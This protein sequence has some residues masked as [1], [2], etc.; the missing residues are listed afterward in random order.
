MDGG[1][2]RPTDVIK[3]WAGYRWRVVVGECDRCGR[4]WHGRLM[5][6]ADDYAGPEVGR[7]LR[8]RFRRQFLGQL[9]A[10]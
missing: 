8:H 4:V 10:Q 1:P 2:V 7:F 9:G 3:Y 5:L 6:R